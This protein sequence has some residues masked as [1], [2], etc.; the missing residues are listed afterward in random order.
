MSIQ[1]KCF[2]LQKKPSVSDNLEYFKT[3]L[4]SSAFMP[5]LMRKVEQVLSMQIDVSKTFKNTSTKVLDFLVDS[6]FEFVDQSLL[7]SQSNFG[8]VD[9]LGGEVVITSSIRG[10]IPDDFPEGVYIRNGQYLTQY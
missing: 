1:L 5:L 4:S 8:P 3:T 7:P 2:A 6:M 9:E 10:K